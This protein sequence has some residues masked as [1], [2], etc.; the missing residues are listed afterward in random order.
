[1]TAAAQTRKLMTDVVEGLLTGADLLFGEEEDE[2]EEE[3][4]EGEN[5]DGDTV[6]FA[7]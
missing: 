5:E 7:G 2:E 3:E 6:E 4:V 1:L